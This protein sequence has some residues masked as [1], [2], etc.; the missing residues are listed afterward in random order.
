MFDKIKK[1][2]E[3]TVTEGKD[4]INKV[5]EDM[6]TKTEFITKEVSLNTEEMRYALNKLLTEYK[7]V[8]VQATVL[9]PSQ[10]VVIII[11][12]VTK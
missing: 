11:C 7:T 12:K 2:V 4:K 6:K 3:D 10:G 1:A 8:D 5:A 9:T